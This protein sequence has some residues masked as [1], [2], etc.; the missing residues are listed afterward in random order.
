MNLP[1][2]IC[3]PD[4]YPCG[5]PDERHR[6]YCLGL[7]CADVSNEKFMEFLTN[8]KAPKMFSYNGKKFTVSCFEIQ[9]R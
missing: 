3:L 2:D 6:E 8:L 4:I 1:L 5:C 7:E 9:D